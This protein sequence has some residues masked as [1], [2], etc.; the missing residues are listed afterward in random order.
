[1]R[2]RNAGDFYVAYAGITESGAVD[3]WCCEPP[4]FHHQ[5][6]T[7]PVGTR[8]LGIDVKAIHGEFDRVRNEGGSLQSVADTIDELLKSWRRPENRIQKKLVI[9]STGAG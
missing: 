1:M 5:I 8:G 6:I 3:V 4:D 2:H 9:E 7:R